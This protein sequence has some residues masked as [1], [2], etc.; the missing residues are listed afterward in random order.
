M[1]ADLFGVKAWRFQ[2]ISRILAVSA[3]LAASGLFPFSQASSEEESVEGRT[4][5]VKVTG[6]YVKV[7]KTPVGFVTRGQEMT[8]LKRSMMNDK[9]WLGVKWTTDSGEEKKGWI[10]EDKVVFKGAAEVTPTVKPAAARPFSKLLEVFLSG[11]ED[12]RADVYQELERTAQIDKFLEAVGPKVVAAADQFFAALKE[13]GREG[14]LLE[15]YSP[16]YVKVCGNQ[17]K[18]LHQ[19]E[20]DEEL[21]ADYSGVWGSHV[22]LLDIGVAVGLK[23]KNKTILE[24]MEQAKPDRHGTPSWIKNG[25]LVILS[26]VN[27]EWKVLA[28][29]QMAYASTMTKNLRRQDEESKPKA[30]P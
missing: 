17:A 2:P 27:K 26:P 13:R 30:A 3:V 7:G 12:E 11:S 6:T 28:T 21:S 20:E 14:T 25:A 22:Y 4:V 8:V 29:R 15:H 5:L 9:P 10:P 19:Q 18:A 16:D 24:M 1:T 23:P